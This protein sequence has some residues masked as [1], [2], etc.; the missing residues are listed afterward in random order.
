MT[1][2]YSNDDAWCGEF[3]ASFYLSHADF[4]DTDVSTPW[5]LP[6]LAQKTF[7]GCDIEDAAYAAE[8]YA[9]S[10]S[11]VVCLACGRCD[12]TDE[13]CPKCGH[14]FDRR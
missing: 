6:W 7:P 3:A 13:P 12:D 2:N 10:L 5:G 14:E 1:T 11:G 9:D 8:V 4:D